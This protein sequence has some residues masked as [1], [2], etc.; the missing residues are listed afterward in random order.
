[1]TNF[2]GKDGFVWFQGVVEDR[3]DPLKLGRCR[4]RCVGWHTNNKQ[5]IP[6]NEL[7]WAYPIQPITSAAMNGIGSSPTGPVEGT[8]VFGFFRDGESGQE[9]MMIGTLGG[10]PETDPNIYLGFNDPNG[11]YPKADHL[12]EPDTNRLARNDGGNQHKIVDENGAKTNIDTDVATADGRTWSEPA[13]P[14]AAEYPKNHVRETESGHIIELDDTP[15]NERIHIFHKDG[16]FEE[17]HPKGEKVVKVVAD[18]YTIVMSNDH[19]HVKGV[20]NLTVDGNCNIRVGGDANIRV[21][22]DCDTD[23]TGNYTLT[24]R[25]GDIRLITKTLVGPDGR[26]RGIFLN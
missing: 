23:V 6:T 25:T 10:I 14:Y 26:R 9:P 21:I 17:Y 1:M 12:V 8:W 13:T 20:E 11:V 4:V 16:S 18:N 7:P 2:M 22:G 24:S 19:V 3:N 15:D 5:D